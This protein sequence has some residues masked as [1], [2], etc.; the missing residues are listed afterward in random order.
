MPP[1]SVVMR[2]IEEA[3]CHQRATPI[4]G[5]PKDTLLASLANASEAY[6]EHL[7]SLFRGYLPPP[8]K[9]NESL[10]VPVPL[11][12]MNAAWKHML[13]PIL[14]QKGNEGAGSL[15]PRVFTFVFDLFTESVFSHTWCSE[16]EIQLSKFFA[17]YFVIA[18]KAQPQL[19][20]SRLN[21]ILAFYE[22]VMQS[23][24]TSKNESTARI[25][26]GAIL[27]RLE[28][29]I[30][31]IGG[32]ADISVDDKIASLSTS[33][34]FLQ[35]KRCEEGANEEHSSET[36]VLGAAVTSHI[37]V[38]FLKEFQLQPGD[39]KA[40]LALVDCAL[41]LMRCLPLSKAE[42]QF[43]QWKCLRGVDG[44]HP[45]TQTVDEC[46]E[47]CGEL[48][49]PTQ[50]MLLSCGPSFAAAED[51]LPL[52]QQ[53]PAPFAARWLAAAWKVFLALFTVSRSVCCGLLT[54]SLMAM[55]DCTAER[56]AALWSAMIF[57]TN[58]A[59]PDVQAVFVNLLC[60]VMK[61]AALSW[62]SLTTR[63]D[64]G[65]ARGSRDSLAVV[66][67]VVVASSGVLREASSRL[68][69][70]AIVL[71][72]R[73]DEARQGRHPAS[74]L[75]VTSSCPMMTDDIQELEDHFAATSVA[76]HSLEG[77]YFVHASE[78]AEW[79]KKKYIVGSAEVVTDHL[80][81]V[82]EGITLLSPDISETSCADWVASLL[83]DIV[84]AAIKADHGTQCAALR[85]LARS[86]PTSHLASH[87]FLLS[88]SRVLVTKVFAALAKGDEKLNA[89]PALLEGVCS[90]EYFTRH[91]VN[92]SL[93]DLWVGDEAARL[94]ISCIKPN[95]RRQSDVFIAA[96]SGSK[97]SHS[98]EKCCE[99]LK[100][101]LSRSGGG[102]RPAP[103]KR[104]REHSDG[105]GDECDALMAAL[106]KCEES[107]QAASRAMSKGPSGGKRT[108]DALSRISGLVGSLQAR[109]TFCKGNLN[110]DVSAEDAGKAS[111]TNR[112]DAISLD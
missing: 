92:I 55:E 6:L 60:D 81:S 107:L 32:S 3:M 91:T 70:V 71:Q 54:T 8:L 26:H 69:S 53:Q 89:S 39:S 49:L 33:I 25:V 1:E 73:H 31:A 66:K 20:C 16:S 100:L 2:A 24:A 12:V 72:R 13:V 94:L 9:S 86:P 21:E 95:G 65:C 110:S 80:A 112:H 76:D 35:A 34:R 45:L 77:R 42:L 40:E 44:T 85:L 36:A 64:E 58:D 59:L 29:V 27:V 11:V 67:R 109:C 38:A 79:I 82:C 19:A 83:L 84:K 37:A 17:S 68:S 48:Q 15:V 28:A 96:A 62:T 52:D 46:Y 87:G 14:Q 97:K 99:E 104:D 56:V 90:L 50:R 22:I 88:V 106:S 102:S 43:P 111:G 105:D 4:E 41:T 51:A 57:F 23:V 98:V 108:V 101:A 47:A 78:T 103:Q 7:F 74:S 5:L 10:G 18:V 75:F 61:A 63:R 93:E 30:S